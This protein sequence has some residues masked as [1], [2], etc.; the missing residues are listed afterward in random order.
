MTLSP[1]ESARRVL[2]AALYAALTSQRDESIPL[3]VI[4]RELRAVCA[5][6]DREASGLSP[7]GILAPQV[8]GD[9]S[10]GD[11][12]QRERGDLTV[13]HEREG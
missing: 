7:V 13:G 2:R 12:E 11:E 1:D 10:A 5:R 4:T 8:Q 9:R 6:V 3:A